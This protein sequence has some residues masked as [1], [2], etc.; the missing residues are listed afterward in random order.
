MCDVLQKQTA[1]LNM[2]H[3]EPSRHM[4]MWDVSGGEYIQVEGLKGALE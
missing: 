4:Y 3:E 1:A 2:P